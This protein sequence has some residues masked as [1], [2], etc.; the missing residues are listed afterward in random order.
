[1]TMI[2]PEKRAIKPIFLVI[3]ILALQSM[4]IGIATK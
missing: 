4:K 2:V 3:G 1:M